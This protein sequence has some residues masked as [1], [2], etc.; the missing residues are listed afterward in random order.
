M[1]SAM[2]ITGVGFSGQSQNNGMVFGKLKDWDLRKRP[3][4]KAKGC[5]GKGHD[6]LFKNPQRHGVCLLTAGCSRT[7]HVHGI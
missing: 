4:L 1:E 6:G 7:G 2:T 5:R 3:D